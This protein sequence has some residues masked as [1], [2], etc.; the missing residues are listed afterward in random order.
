MDDASNDDPT[1][2][3][4]CSPE[5]LTQLR[6]DGEL[7]GFVE[8]ICIQPFKHPVP[9]VRVRFIS[10]KELAPCDEKTALL[11]KIHYFQGV[12]SK[13]PQVVVYEE[14]ETLPGMMALRPS[15]I[16]P[17]DLPEAKDG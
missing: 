3:V 15:S 17:G 10:T 5:G 6:V 11:E 7:I 2:T 16:P 12:L 8:E 13:C 4:S 9:N 14:A 1:V